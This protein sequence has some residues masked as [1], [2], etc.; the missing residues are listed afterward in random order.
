MCHEGVMKSIPQE[1]RTYYE[2]FMCRLALNGESHM[3]ERVYG[4]DTITPYF[5]RQEKVQTAKSLLL[6]LSY[7]NEEHLT[8]YLASSKNDEEDKM[9]AINKWKEEETTWMK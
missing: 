1:K 8:C 2:N 4:L 6:F 9:A 3:E 5:T 7:I